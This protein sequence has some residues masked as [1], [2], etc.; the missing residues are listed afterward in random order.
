[1]GRLQLHPPAGDV[2]QAMAASDARSSRALPGSTSTSAPEAT[3]DWTLRRW[4]SARTDRLNRA[5]WQRAHGLPINQDL[6]DHLPTLR[7]RCTY[8]LANNPFLEGIVNTYATDLVGAYGPRLQ[9]H[10]SNPQYNERLERIWRDWFREPDINQQLSGADILRVWVR[11]W[12]AK[13]EDLTQLVTDSA[14][15]GPVQMR[16]LVH[17]PDRLATPANLFSDSQ[18][19]LGVRLSQTGRPTQYYLR[20]E[21]QFGPLSILAAKYTPVPADMILHGFVTLEP[22]QVRGVPWLASCL[23]IIADLRDYDRQVLDAA[24]M[25]ANQS[26]WFFTRHPDAPYMHVNEVTEIERGTASTAPPG[27]EPFALNPTQPTTTYVDYRTE[28]LRELG[29]PINMPLMMVRLGSEDHN[30]SS[31]RFDGQIYQRG[32]A[33]A[34]T[35]RL[36][37]PLNRCVHEIAREAELARQLPPRPPDVTYHWLHNKP[38]HVDPSKEANAEATYLANGTVTLEEALAAQGK[39]LEEHVE[40]LRYI[41]QMLATAGIH[42]SWQHV[43][44][45]PNQNAPPGDEQ[46]AAPDDQPDDQQPEPAEA[47]SAA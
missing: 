43:E 17:D 23:S 33:V 42:L 32:I 38:P 8:E 36:E 27:W 2:A 29:R 47:A 1:M 30:Y 37:R 14:A 12:F 39:D 44:P 31:A 15:P 6:A 22:G 28:R 21:Q 13:G 18:V 41:D 11:Q 34:Q 19:A 20:D 45:D 10:S 4:E 16:L 35:S 7:A 9:V 3:A 46:A 25:A 26:L 40:R 5:H 24:T